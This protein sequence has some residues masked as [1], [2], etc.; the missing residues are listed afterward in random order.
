MKT[1]ANRNW[2]NIFQ[3]TK[4]QRK[5]ERLSFPATEKRRFKA[6]HFEAAGKHFWDTYSTNPKLNQP[7]K[8]VSS[9][10]MKEAF[11]EEGVHTP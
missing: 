8:K 2:K 4:Q 5:E 11:M 7:V 3:H 6:D 1:F 9:V 10:L